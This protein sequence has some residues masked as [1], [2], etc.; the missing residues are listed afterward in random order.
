MVTTQEVFNKVALHLLTQ[1]KQAKVDNKCRYRSNDGLSCAVGCLI[2][3]SLYDYRLEGGT[4]FAVLQF[5]AGTNRLKE[6]AAVGI[7][8][9][10]FALLTELQMVHDIREPQDWYSHLCDIAKVL[11]CTMPC[12]EYGVPL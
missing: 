4:V 11:D 5:A 3:D 7:S 6:F 2:P 12:N 10:N 9:S 1:F 8:E